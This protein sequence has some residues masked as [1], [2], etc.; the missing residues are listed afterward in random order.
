MVI[1]REGI[2]E[3]EVKRIGGGGNG[4]VEV[5]SSGGSCDSAGDTEIPS[6]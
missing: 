1:K 6:P 4:N 5:S 3:K 2:P